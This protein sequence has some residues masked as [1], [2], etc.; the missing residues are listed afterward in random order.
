V[1]ARPGGQKHSC[2]PRGACECSNF[3]PLCGLLFELCG[4]E[5]CG[6]DKR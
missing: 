6:V 3:M 1:I 2:A 5:L 4:V